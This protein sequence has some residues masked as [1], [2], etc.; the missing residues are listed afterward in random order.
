MS[1]PKRIQRRRTK[2][3]RMPEGAIY[4]GRPTRWGN[5]FTIMNAHRQGWL[6]YDDR[7]TSKVDGY[8]ASL[9]SQAE[10]RVRATRLYRQHMFR[11]ADLT[12]LRGHDLACWCPLDQAC[13]ADVLLEIANRDE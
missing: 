1:A 6:I 13:H 3:W 10:A 7:D 5:P 12:A 11:L 8:I 4:V 2:G 9:P